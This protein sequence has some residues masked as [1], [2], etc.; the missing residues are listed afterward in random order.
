MIQDIGAEKLNNSYIPDAV[1]SPGDTLFCFVN[2]TE[3]CLDIIHRAHDVVDFI[4][5]L[6]DNTLQ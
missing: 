6:L 1:P 5:L 4:I 2:S 3:S